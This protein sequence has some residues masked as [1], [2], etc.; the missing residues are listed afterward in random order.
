MTFGIDDVLNPKNY[1]IKKLDSRYTGNQHFKY[2][3]N[4]NAGIGNPGIINLNNPRIRLQT[5][6]NWFWTNYGPSGEY[7]YWAT[8]NIVYA[9]NPNLETLVSK[10]WAW[11]TDYNN[12]RIY[13]QN[14]EILSHF[15]L[16]HAD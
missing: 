8:C 5:A 15:V 2:L 12:Y 9:G 14:D 13:V 7:E 6:R 3:I 16:A 1:K 10:S 11:D 4:F